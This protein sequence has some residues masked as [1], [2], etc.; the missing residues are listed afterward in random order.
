MSTA[1]ASETCHISKFTL[2]LLLSLINTTRCGPAQVTAQTKTERIDQIVRYYHEYGYLN[3]TVLVGENGRIIY[4]KG[5]GEADFASHTPNTPRTRF[6]IGS[7]TK[8]FTALLVL[9]QVD[10]GKLT[11]ND[12]V[13]KLLPWYR[14]DTGSRMTIE[15]LLHHT[16]GLPP[17]FDSPA[18]S[19]DAAAG[20][21]YAPEDFAKQLCSPNFVSEPGTTW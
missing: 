4:E 8:Q 3:G 1:P 21:F 20:K 15:Q 2:L 11:L 7:I 14:R 18:F 6:A 13:A 17:D 5:L 10:E 19:G 16:S 12:T 9:Q